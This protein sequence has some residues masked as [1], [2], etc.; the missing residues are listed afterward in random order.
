MDNRPHKV[1]DPVASGQRVE[2]FVPPTSASSVRPESLPLSIIYEDADVLV[3]DK[4]ADMLVH[5]SGVDGSG[6]LVNAL[7]HHTQKQGVTHTPGPVTRLDRDTSGLVLFAKHPHAHH[8]LGVALGA[9]KVRREYTAFVHGEI[10]PPSGVIDAPIRRA[11]DGLTRRI[12]S[13]D[14]QPARTHYRT[15]ERYRFVGPATQGPPGGVTRL[16]LWLETGRTHQIRVHLA[17]SGHPIV[18]D[19]MYGRAD[20][21]AP[22]D[23][24]A[25]HAFRLTFIHPVH[26]EEIT[27]VSDPPPDMEALRTSLVKDPTV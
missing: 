4:P 14:G 15:V 20:P 25:L 6:T 7:A 18:G 5:P 11:D 8:R 27:L 24:Q 2:L 21:W 16:E 13:D 3:V 26:D 10:Q 17:H 12:V 9:G 19:L 1:R 22:I 23:R